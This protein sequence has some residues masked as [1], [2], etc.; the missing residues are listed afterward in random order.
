MAAEYWQ[1]VINRDV[2]KSMAALKDIVSA[3]GS[4]T[5]ME[6]INQMAETANILMPK[7]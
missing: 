5:A 3:Y 2:P 7:S 4:I 1:Q 6:A